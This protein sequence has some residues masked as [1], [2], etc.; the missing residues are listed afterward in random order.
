MA[1]SPEPLAADEPEVLIVGA[2]PV[3]V[4]LACEL[5]QQGV[6]IRLI[7]R[8]PGIDESDPHSKGILVW[9]RSLEVL[10]RIGV[11]DRLAAIGH[12]SKGVN[13]YSEGR[14]RGT[15]HLHRLADSP[16]PFV[17][18][19]PQRETERVLRGRLAELG[20][21]IEFGTALVGL[22]TAGELPE[23]RLV[24]GATAET[25]VPRYLVGADGPGSITRELLGIRF[26]GEA[27]DVTYAIADAPI[28]GDVPENAQY[29]YSRDGVVALVPLA[30][31]Y[32]RI[33]ANI[34]HRGPDEDDPSA[35]LLEEVINRRAHTRFTVGTPLWT[36]SFRP[37][38]GLA[39][40]FGNGRCFL[41]GDSAHVISPA[42]G[43]GMN[44]GFQDAANLGW[45]LGG[46]VRG[47]LDAAALDTY[48]SERTV[49]AV[50]MAK[51]SA[52]Q[53][54]FAMQRKSARI[55]VRDAV[56]VAAR[57]TG[58]LERVLVPL[59]AQTD[60]DYAES[61]SDPLFRRIAHPARPGQRV[62]LFAAP[63][64][65]PADG[66]AEPGD[67]G[68]GGVPPIDPYHY[69]VVLWPGRRTPADWSAT[70]AGL[71][72]RFTGQARVLDLGAVPAAAAPAL[73]RA[74]GNRPVIATVRPDGH[75]AHLAPASAPER[76]QAFLRSTAPAQTAVP[77]LV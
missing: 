44:I 24:R 74:F 28:S 53:A 57:W 71:L 22:D 13:Y 19:L 32:Y 4:A 52:A 60:V 46:V 26:D 47:R 65:G 29:Y 76:A 35:Q 55:A 6:R 5:L 15:A 48:H 12:R 16:Y 40:R 64:G 30:N 25:V 1:D 21:T 50:R 39:E 62:P 38:L 75:L 9:P 10:G 34:P 43:Q 72:G 2:G 61:A 68:F 63:A 56:F 45:K 54:R 58:L 42:G 51:T 37:R 11:A 59:L 77:S 3:G 73:R 23:A 8:R 41:V 20:G 27:I 49:G 66:A 31:G 70:A 17:L 33:A 36:R 67:G 14:L 18:T 7:D 69:T